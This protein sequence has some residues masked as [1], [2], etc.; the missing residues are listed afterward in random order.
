MWPSTCWACRVRSK[1]NR[2]LPLQGITVITHEHAIAAPFCTPQL[3]DMCARVINIERPGTGDSAR[4]YDA[5]ELGLSFPFFC[6]N[7]SQENIAPDVQ[8]AQTAA[9]IEHIF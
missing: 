7:R 5:R 6:P 3:A 2:M 4:G 1:G 8:H 9:I